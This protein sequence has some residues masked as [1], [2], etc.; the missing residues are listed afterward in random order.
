MALP[1]PPQ[2]E[3]RVVIACLLQQVLPGPLYRWAISSLHSAVIKKCSWPMRFVRQSVGPPQYMLSVAMRVSHRLS[4]YRHAAL[5]VPARLRLQVDRTTCSS[6]AVSARGDQAASLA[7]G[8]LKLQV[9]DVSVAST[10]ISIVRPTVP[11]VLDWYMEPE[12]ERGAIPS[13]STGPDAFQSSLNCM[14]LLCWLHKSTPIAC[15]SQ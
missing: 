12:P 7:N 10:G 6:T 2:K 4:S 9:E 14:L 15:R 13:C 8:K 1:W 11:N 3:C 5:A